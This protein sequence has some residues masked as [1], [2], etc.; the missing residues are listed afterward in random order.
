MN[1]QNITFDVMI[2]TID[3]LLKESMI[4]IQTMNNLSDLNIKFISNMYIIMIMLA[5]WT[6]ILKI[7]LLYVIMSST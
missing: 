6:T 2:Q 5:C 3:S 1:E 4:L 7:E